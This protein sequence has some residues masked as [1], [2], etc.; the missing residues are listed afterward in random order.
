MP[1]KLDVVG[2]RLSA[3]AN[4]KIIALGR[5]RPDARK[6][7]PLLASQ[8]S[9]TAPQIITRRPPNVRLSRAQ[10]AINMGPQGPLQPRR[11]PDT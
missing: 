10:D 9:E 11:P 1:L 8:V 3:S 4:R 5:F 7:P 2:M 6:F